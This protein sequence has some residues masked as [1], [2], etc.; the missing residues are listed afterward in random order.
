[1][2]SGATLGPLTGNTAGALTSHGLLNKKC[3]FH[4]DR[5]SVDRLEFQWSTVELARPHYS[6]CEQ[7][8]TVALEIIRRGNL[9]E[10]SFVTVKVGKSFGM[11]ELQ[12][13]V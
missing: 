7:Q 13:A 4:S 11:E 12:T 2:M 10:S 3:H 6:V 9:A 5:S 8:E 1:M